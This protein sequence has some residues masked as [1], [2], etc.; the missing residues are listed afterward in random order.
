[1]GRAVR[2]RHSREQDWQGLL[3][4]LPTPPTPTFHNSSLRAALAVAGHGAISAGSLPWPPLS[5]LKPGSASMPPLVLHQSCAKSQTPQHGAQ[6]LH[7]LTPELPAV[8]PPSLSR[9]GIHLAVGHTVPSWL[10][11]A[12]GPGIWPKPSRAPCAPLTYGAGITHSHVCSPT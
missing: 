7:N 9:T 5:P 8:T 2:R 10:P 3:M 6:D 11:S 4:S 12:R 1:M